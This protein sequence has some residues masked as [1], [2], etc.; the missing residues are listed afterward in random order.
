MAKRRIALPR[1]GL[2]MVLMASSL[3]LRKSAATAGHYHAI[4]NFLNSTLPVSFYR[5]PRAPYSP[6]QSLEGMA[7]TPT[8]SSRCG[9]KLHWFIKNFTES[10]SIMT[11][12]AWSSHTPA[13]ASRTV[14]T[15]AYS[16]S[17]LGQA[18]KCEGP[19]DLEENKTQLE[20][21][22]LSRRDWPHPLWVKTSRWRSL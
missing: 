2:R 19:D 17:S 10:V 15:L 16:A 1:W 18:E 6:P 9:S 5:V 22:H 13:G 21:R 7:Q 4:Q 14:P 8:T 12:F 3:N 11:K 20:Q